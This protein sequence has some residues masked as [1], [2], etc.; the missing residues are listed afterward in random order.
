LGGTSVSG[1]V[2]LLDRVFATTE[3]YWLLDEF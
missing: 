3:K 2:A 1:N